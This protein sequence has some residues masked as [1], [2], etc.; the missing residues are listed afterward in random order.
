[1]SNRVKSLE[2]RNEVI[3]VIE[4]KFEMKFS[5]GFND[6]YKV[7]DNN[8]VRRLKGNLYNVEENIYYFNLGKDRNKEYNDLVLEID[9]FVKNLDY[10]D[11]EIRLKKKVVYVD[12]RD[13]EYYEKYNNCIISMKELRD[14]E[15]FKEKEL[16]LSIVFK[17]I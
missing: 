5:Y 8:L 7:K 14:I 2:I 11:F 9:N 17:D 15:V 12:K 3:K 13:R 16:I 6:L 10:K 1:M 4:D